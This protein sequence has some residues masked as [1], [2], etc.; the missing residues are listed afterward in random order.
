MSLTKRWVE[1][2]EQSSAE[3]LEHAR[4]RIRFALRAANRGF[5]DQDTLNDIAALLEAATRDLE[6]VSTNLLML[7]NHID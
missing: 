4:S 3:R 2:Q 5:P 7:Q 6:E 1:A